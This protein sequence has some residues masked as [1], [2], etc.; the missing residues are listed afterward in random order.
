MVSWANQCSTLLKNPEEP[1]EES[2]VKFPDLLEDANLYE[3]AGVSFGKGE[4]YRLYLS[5]KKLTESLP[6]EVERL[7]LVGKIN[8]RTLPYF[9]VEGVAAEEEEVCTHTYTR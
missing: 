4:L 1:P 6:G 8:T 5:I 2:G 7:R 9:V 3:W